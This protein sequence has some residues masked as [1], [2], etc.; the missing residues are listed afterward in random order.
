MKGGESQEDIGNQTKK[1]ADAKREN[2]VK[3][4][5]KKADEKKGDKK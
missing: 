5:Y 1:I 2:L 4:L 3:R